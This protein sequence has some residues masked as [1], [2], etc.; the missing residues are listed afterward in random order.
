[1]RLHACGQPATV[2]VFLDG[3][4]PGTPMCAKHGN[5]YVDDTDYRWSQIRADDPQQRCGFVLEVGE[6]RWPSG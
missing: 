6:D 2:V 1:V 4:G 5:I 3:E